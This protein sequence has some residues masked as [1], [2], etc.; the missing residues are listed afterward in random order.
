MLR[1]TGLIAICLA[2]GMT[3]SANAQSTQTQA[4]ESLMTETRRIVTGHQDGKSIF[5]V[6]ENVAPITIGLIP[7]GGFTRVFGSEALQ[8]PLANASVDI[9]PYFPPSGG[10]TVTIATFPPDPKSPPPADFDPAPLFAEAMKKLPGL[11]EVMEPDGSMMH[12]TATVDVVT[13]LSGRIVLELDDGAKRELGAGDV[14]IQN[15]TRHAWRN[16][17]DESVVMH[18]VSIGVEAGV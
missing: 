5:V 6:D 16:P 9:D 14:L 10:A 11:L 12:T 4:G 3:F 13:I 1:S 7:G 15:G 17:F 2:A 18:I 8:I